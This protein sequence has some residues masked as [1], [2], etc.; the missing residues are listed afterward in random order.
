MSVNQR[1]KAEDL[2]K[3]RA[4]ARE[5]RK[6]REQWQSQ[7]A[8][9]YSELDDST[10]PDPNDFELQDNPA[11]RFSYRKMSEVLLELIDPLSL[12]DDDSDKLLG[13][14]KLGMIA[15]NLTV[16]PEALR[17]EAFDKAMRK[18]PKEMQYCLAALIERKLALFPDDSRYIVDVFLK[19]HPNGETS[20]QAMSTLPPQKDR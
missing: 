6:H 2:A 12:P 8:P 20:L 15:W 17:S 4:K 11:A 19:N 13:L 10:A 3:A 9:G 16:V 14:A 5:R 1:K 18:A 7:W